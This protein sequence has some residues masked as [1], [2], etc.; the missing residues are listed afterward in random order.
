MCV[1]TRSTPLTWKLRQQ[2]E[3]LHA[4]AAQQEIRKPCEVYHTT[5]I[6]MQYVYENA[7]TLYKHTD[8]FR[9][10]ISIMS[11]FAQRSVEQL[12]A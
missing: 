7:L 1:T 2:P 12:F 10:R 3:K 5:C 11:D 4:W 6:S 8:R 9:P